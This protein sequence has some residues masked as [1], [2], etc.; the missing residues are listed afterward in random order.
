MTPG[1]DANACSTASPIP[2]DWWEM[3]AHPNMEWNHFI[4]KDRNSREPI[5]WVGIREL[6]SE[7]DEVVLGL[8]HLYVRP[9]SRNQGYAK[10]LLTQVLNKLQL[11]FHS[12]QV[13]LLVPE[14]NIFALRTFAGLHFETTSTGNVYRRELPEDFPE[15][16]QT[17]Q[18]LEKGT[19]VYA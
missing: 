8:H 10:F 7:G 13:K 5:A 11:K 2:R 12:C 17:E 4:L 19:E 16:F 3:C 1:T 14:V 6:T 18:S 9:D 15:T